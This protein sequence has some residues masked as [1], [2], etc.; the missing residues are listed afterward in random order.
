M[1]PL[2]SLLLRRRFTSVLSRT[3][4]L[5]QGTTFFTLGLLLGVLPISPYSAME[6]SWLTE[7]TVDLEATN[8][9][10]VHP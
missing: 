6:P 8:R 1:F 7:L 2:L 4:V 9:K 10:V 5:S 3:V